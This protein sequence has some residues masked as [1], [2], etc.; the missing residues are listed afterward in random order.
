MYDYIKTGMNCV[1]RNFGLFAFLALR[2][3]ARLVSIV[4]RFV[5]WNVEAQ[6]DPDLQVCKQ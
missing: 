3:R 4:L 1:E 5:V 6:Y 2:D